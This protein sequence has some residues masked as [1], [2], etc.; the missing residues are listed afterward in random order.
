M[1]ALGRE[2]A[3]FERA[4][5]F[6][7][8]TRA[9]MIV[10]MT[11]RRTSQ[12]GYSKRHPVLLPFNPTIARS[13]ADAGYATAA[14]VD[15]AN[16]AAQHGYDRGFQS[17]RETWQEK[18][19]A[20][21][22]D[23]ARAITEGAVRFLREGRSRPFFLWLHYVNPHGP[24]T[25]PPPFDTAFL[26][27]EAEAGPRL[28][29]VTG[30]HGGIRRQWMV[31]GRENLGYYVAQYDGEIAAVDREVGT[32]LEALGAVGLRDRTL[33]VLTS[34]HG[35]SLGEH[36]YYFD[37]GADLFEPSLA[38]PLI[39][40]GPGVRPGTRSEAFASTL[41]VFPTILDAAKVSYP[42]D[43]A[44]ESLL[45][46]A[47]GGPGPSRERLFA[48]NDRNLTA[49]FDRRFK[50]VATPQDGRTRFELFDRVA[51]TG[52]TREV[53]R[54]RPEDLRRQRRDLELYQE[55][56]DREWARTRPLAEG[57]PG[58]AKM[59]PEACEQ[60]VALGYI[61]GCPP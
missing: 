29:P 20:T 15:N 18:A 25:P 33:V 47:A 43:L 17:Y 5:T 8:K 41:D 56:A 39:V 32:V 49:T 40:A 4:Y 35:E 61:E 10:M 13:L 48:Q 19:L 21:E 50:L 31:P 22:M 14:V 9:S 52:E 1:D 54:T 26:D 58:E 6:W 27:A 24:Y 2:G 36:D 51:D 37:H 12:N 7:P 44:G 42:P 34:D 23:R 46:A 59:T 11:G 53:S 55:R 38:I 57:R 30:F 28:K 45:G 60:L 3:V 16:V